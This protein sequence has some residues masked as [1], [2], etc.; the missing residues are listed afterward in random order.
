M[1]YRSKLEK[2]VGDTLGPDW[3]YEGARILYQQPR[4][5]TPD[6]IRGR[7][8]LEVK[9]F[10][11]SGDQSKYLA[12][13]RECKRLGYR[14]VFVFQYPNKPVRKKAK[15]TMSQWAEKHDIEWTTIDEVGRYLNE[16]NYIRYRND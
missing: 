9:G 3:L 7:T 8:Y 10:F 15:L 11:R 12:I 5:Y 6:F 14:F 4:A 1:K 2:R 13:G 16:N